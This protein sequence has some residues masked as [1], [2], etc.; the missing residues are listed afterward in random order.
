MDYWVK[1]YSTAERPSSVASVARKHL[2]YRQFGDSFSHGRL[3]GTVVGTRT[4]LCVVRKLSRNS[5]LCDI[6]ATKF[7]G[8]FCTT[9]HV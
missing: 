3:E 4:E 9:V 2:P 5:I 6:N 7:G 1:A 8:C